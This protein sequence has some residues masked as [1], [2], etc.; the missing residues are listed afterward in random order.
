MVAFAD[1]IYLL[2]Q[3]GAGFQ[4]E[5]ILRAVN[6]SLPATY[7]YLL[8]SYL[9]RYDLVNI[10]PGVMRELSLIQ[11]SF[12]SR[13]LETIHRI[14]DD[15][16]IKATGFG[17]CLSE[18]SVAIIWKTLMLPGPILPKLALIPINLS[19]PQYCRIQ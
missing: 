10:A 1:T 16:L 14:I 9:L 18:R 19:L 7:L 5:W 12:G 17:P 3:A 4:W 13:G 2:K 6:R 8:L 15:Y 11:R